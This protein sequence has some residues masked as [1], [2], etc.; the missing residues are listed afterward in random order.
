MKLRFTVADLLL[1]G[2]LGGAV[3]LVWAI[4]ALVW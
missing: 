2:A 1:C 3:L 4:A